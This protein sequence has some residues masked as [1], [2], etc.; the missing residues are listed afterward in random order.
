MEEAWR[1]SMCRKNLPFVFSLFLFGTL[2]AS[3]QSDPTTVEMLTRGI[4][5]VVAS[6]TSVQLVMEG[7]VGS[8][9]PI[10]APDG[11]FLFT[12]NDSSRVIRIDETGEI[13]LYLDNTNE[14]NGLGFDSKGRLISAQRGIPQ[15]GVLLPMRE[16]LTN[17]SEGQ[18]LMRPN[19]L[20]VN[21]KDGIYFTDPGTNP[22]TRNPAVHYI[23]PDGKVIQIAEDIE[24]P[25]GIMLS[26][27][28]TTL[29]VAN[30]YGAFV[31][32]FDIQ[33]DGT[34]RNRRDFVELEGV[35]QTE[36]GIRS[37]A[38]GLAIDNTGR[39]YVASDA[40]VQVIS[41]QGEHLGTITIPRRPQNV[42]FAGPSKKTLYVVG[43]DAVYKIEMESQGFLG[44]PK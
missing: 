19:D 25:N 14:S 6:E 39:L 1:K 11:A 13:S 9:G 29:Y 21:S 23:K 18:P 31:L 5:G 32:A 37:G 3:G 30:T 42:A 12:E 33:P 22:P 4:P 36:R 34:V 43:S 20:V 38:D 35:R 15:I 24:R 27:D 2:N 17:T 16:M 10:A 28:E 26:P 40:G 7:L 44:R 8:E 41:P